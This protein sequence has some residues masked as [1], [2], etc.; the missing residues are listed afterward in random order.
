MKKKQKKPANSE[1]K[2]LND[3]IKENDRVYGEHLKATA[4]V[5]KEDV[6]KIQQVTK[7]AHSSVKNQ[8]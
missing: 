1:F 5:D 6:K 3:A 4:K 8:H 7:S 2:A